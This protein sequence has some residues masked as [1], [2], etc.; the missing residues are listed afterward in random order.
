MAAAAATA[1]EKAKQDLET[2]KK[3]VTAAEE[4][5]QKVQTELTKRQQAF[6]T[7]TSAQQ[8]AQAAIPAHQSIIAEGAVRQQTLQRHLAVAQSRLSGPEHAIL[9]IAISSDDATIVSAHADG[10][11][12]SY[13]VSD[14]QPML[15][16]VAA[17]EGPPTQVALA[18]DLVCA[19]CETSSP[20][21]INTQ[22]H[23]ELEH[24]IGSA[25]GDSIIS[26]RVTA[27]DFRPDGMSIAV[28]SGPASRFGDVKV[29]AVSNG[30]L[31]RDFGEV[32]SDTVLGLKFSPDG[33]Q[34]AS[35]AADKVVR[36]L[37]V[38]SGQVIR[39]LEGHTHHVLAL[40]WQDD[41]Q[42]IAS[43]SADQTIKIWNVE[44]GEQR[45]TISGFSKEI[46][47][48]DFVRTSN[49]IVTACADGNVRL[50]DSSSGNSLRTFN[51]AGDFL[52]TLRVTPDG[53]K[54]LAGGQS[55]VVRIWNLAD[56]ETAP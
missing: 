21:L 30:Q 13:R 24:V 51:A 42:T 22:T 8:R 31:V 4:A 6:D 53:Q 38:S 39:S 3:A 44:T 26:D 36:L 5:K 27:I 45:R 49:Q 20:D 15:S 35:A 18:G 2:H 50:S 11:I 43:A 46:T 7:A 56:W 28:G 16:E 40:D 14:G 52:F 47:A 33:R 1:A 34:I 41:G 10:T 25:V 29:F 23:W 32:H 55:G 17:I 54:L 19:L 37:D 48:V 9:D 12:R